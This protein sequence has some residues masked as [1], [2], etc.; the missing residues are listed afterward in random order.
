MSFIY[1]IYLYTTAETW[2][3]FFGI[4]S[5]DEGHEG[6]DG[7]DDDDNGRWRSC[8]SRDV[9]GVMADPEVLLE[10]HGLVGWGQLEP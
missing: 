3:L 5:E 8:D 1:I 6:D 2:R 9:S 7:A 10:L 4:K